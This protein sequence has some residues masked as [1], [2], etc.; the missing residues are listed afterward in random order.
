MTAPSAIP[1]AAVNTPLGAAVAIARRDLLEFVRDRRTLFVTLLL[2]MVTYPLVALSSALGVRTAVTDLEARAAPTPLTVAMSGADAGALAARIDRV[3]KGGKPA[4]VGDA[5]WPS[6]T[7][8]LHGDP[9]TAITAVED[10]AADVWVDAPEGIVAALDAQGTVDLDVRFPSR[11]PIGRSREQFEGVIRGVA[12]AIRTGRVSRAGLPESLLQPI[13]IR[14][15]GETAGGTTVATEQILP[16]LTA[17]ILVLLAVLT[18]T[19]AFY[20]AIDAIAGEKERGTIETLLMAPC[21]TGSIVFGK[22]LAVYAVTLATLAANCVSIA[23]TSA[24]GLRFLPPGA[25]S[26]L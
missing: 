9:Q 20:P 17:S 18:M 7:S 23:L 22:F 13:R 11:R 10:G 12:E 6:S 24:V 2:P 26:R 4:G 14:I 1:D 25:A 15:L 3:V 5:P 19:G 8:F 16:A 21:S